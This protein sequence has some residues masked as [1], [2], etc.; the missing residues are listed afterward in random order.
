MGLRVP[1]LKLLAWTPTLLVAQ[2]AKLVGPSPKIGPRSLKPK[3]ETLQ[4]ELLNAGGKQRP[5]KPTMA[6][7]IPV[8][9]FVFCSSCVEAHCRSNAEA[10]FFVFHDSWRCLINGTPSSEPQVRSSHDNE[11]LGAGVLLQPFI[12]TVSRSWVRMVS[13]SSLPLSLR[14][15]QLG[16]HIRRLSVLVIELRLQVLVVLHSCCAG[17]AKLR[18]MFS[19]ACGFVHQDGQPNL[20]TSCFHSVLRETLPDLSWS[21]AESRCIAD[22][23]PSTVFLGRN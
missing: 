20:V 23:K 10:A 21:W 8:L 19:H 22:Q 17:F 9:L 6:N 5:R 3:A 11:N 15:V 4:L 12:S 2:Q 1:K 16:L 18:G 13:S 7:L 14:V